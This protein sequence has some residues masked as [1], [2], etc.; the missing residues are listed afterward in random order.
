MAHRGAAAYMKMNFSSYQKK[1]SKVYHK[2]GNM[3]LKSI[4]SIKNAGTAFK[5]NWNIIL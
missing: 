1:Y 3:L 5:Q 2:K 4:N